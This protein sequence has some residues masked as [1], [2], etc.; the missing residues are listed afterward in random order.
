MVGLDDES[1]VA[2]LEGD[3]YLSS[4]IDLRP[5]FHLYHAHVGIITGVAWDHINVFPTYDLYKEQFATFMKQLPAD[6]SLIYCKADADLQDLVQTVQPKA[7]LIGYDAPEYFVDGKLTHVVIDNE[8]YNLQ[9]V[10]KHNMQNMM[11]AMHACASVGVSRAIFMQAMTKFKGTAKRLEILKENENGIV[12]RDF[13]HAPSKLKATIE[14][15]KSQYP[16]QKL[17]AVYELHTYSSLNKAFLPHYHHTMQKADIAFVLFSEHALQMK[18]LPPLS[19]DE[20]ANGFGNSVKVFTN[21]NELRQAI[22]AAY[23]GNEH[24]L[25]MS[26]GTFD[27]MDLAF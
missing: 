13:A 17:I 3:E 26:S 23:S 6:G 19:I 2:V 18:K 15:V 1:E 24:I 27:G 21:Q 4:A 9:I 16:T 10:G 20:V 7:K 8:Y 12:F 11:A 14:A 22:L 25:L 5:K